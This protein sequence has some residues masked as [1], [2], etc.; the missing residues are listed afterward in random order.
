MKFNVSSEYN[1]VYCQHSE[2]VNVVVA[3]EQQYNKLYR[4]RNF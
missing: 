2:N 3:D 4:R 1:L